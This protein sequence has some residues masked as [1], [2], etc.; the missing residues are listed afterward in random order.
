[1][2]SESII[3]AAEAEKFP[4]LTGLNCLNDEVVDIPDFFT[5]NNRESLDFA[6]FILIQFD[7]AMIRYEEI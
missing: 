1:M 7:A 3:P 2:T 6:V 5:R 4:T